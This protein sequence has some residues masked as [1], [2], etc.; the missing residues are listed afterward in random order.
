[1]KIV[2]NEKKMKKMS[3]FDGRKYLKILLVGKNTKDTTGTK[4]IGTE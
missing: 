4:T 2:E 3:D 1:L